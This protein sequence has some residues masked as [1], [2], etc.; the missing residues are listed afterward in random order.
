MSDAVIVGIIGAGSTVGVALWSWFRGRPKDR[1]EVE[2]Q[3]QAALSERFEDAD[4]L[5]RY[6]QEQVK[7][8]VEAA[9]AP[10]REEITKLK[11]RQGRIYDAFRR[12]YTQLWA[13]D[14]KGREGPLPSL[15]AELMEE[16]RLAHLLELP[17]EDTEPIH[18]K[19]PPTE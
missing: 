2:A 6:V 8:A 4:S 12:F 17:F 3:R 11:Q 10:L 9:V 18:P 1:V 13:W 19:K 14:R 16:L 15:T 7:A 5:T